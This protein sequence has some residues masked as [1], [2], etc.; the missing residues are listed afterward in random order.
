M[1]MTSLYPVLMTADVA[2]A[3]AFYIDALE[4]EVVFESDWYVSLR[5]GAHELAL[6]AY[7]HETI[8]EESRKLPQGV[9]IN[10]EVDNVDAVYSR[11]ITA[12]DYQEIAPL[13]DEAFGQRHFIISG[14]DAVLVDIIQPIPPSEEYADSYIGN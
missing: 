12:G 7:D 3:S 4:M 2:R 13:K 5:K 11:L 10:F 9:I 14:P 8:P 1:S 6:L